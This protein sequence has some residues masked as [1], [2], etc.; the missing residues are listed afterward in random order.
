MLW[1]IIFLN[2]GNEFIIIYNN[3]KWNTQL[4]FPLLGKIEKNPNLNSVYRSPNIRN[5]INS[6]Y[7]GDSLESAPI[8]LWWSLQFTSQ[9]RLRKLLDQRSYSVDGT[10][11]LG[12][13]YQGKHQVA[14]IKYLIYHQAIVGTSPPFGNHP[15]IASNPSACSLPTQFVSYFP[16][17]FGL[18]T[19]S[20]SV[21]F[22]SPSP[23]LFWTFYSQN[24]VQCV[25]LVSQVAQLVTN[26]SQ[27]ID[28]RIYLLIVNKNT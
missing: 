8:W 17:H 21:P 10:A 15:R 14:L 28:P 9:D 6:S 27:Q 4:W 3:K 2:T 25:P 23:S 18:T 11:A 20:F 12:V 24:V 26:H 16:S 7:H 19:T 1:Q 13:G 5:V 22:F